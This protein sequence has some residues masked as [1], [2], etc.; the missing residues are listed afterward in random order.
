MVR[1]P[2][3]GQAMSAVQYEFAY[4]IVHSPHFVIICMSISDRHKLD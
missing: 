1:L 4:R 3:A 2:S